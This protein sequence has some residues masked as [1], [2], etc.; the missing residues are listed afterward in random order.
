MS[1]VQVVVALL[2]FAGYLSGNNGRS[3]LLGSVAG[4]TGLLPSVI[5]SDLVW[6]LDGIA[7]FL[8]DVFFCIRCIG[9]L[10]ILIRRV[11]LCCVVFR[12]V[13][14][15]PLFT[16]HISIEEFPSHLA[17]G[18]I[19]QLGF[20]GTGHRAICHLQGPRGDAEAFFDH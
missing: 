10:C 16:T 8:L 6:Y 3:L 5:K 17:T 20:G 11:V 13:S 2:K 12:S 9:L 15:I 18:G 14:L 1:S 4:K 7:C 19:L